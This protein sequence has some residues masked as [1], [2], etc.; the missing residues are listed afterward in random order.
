MLE[1]AFKERLVVDTGG[2]ITF[3][4]GEHVNESTADASIVLTQEFA[5]MFGQT[6]SLNWIPTHALTKGGVQLFG[7]ELEI[8]I[9]PNFHRKFVSANTFR[10]KKDAKMGIAAIALKSGLMDELKEAVAKDPSFGKNSKF[11]DKRKATLPPPSMLAG[12]IKEEDI[13]SMDK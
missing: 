13:P 1:A 6:R 3:K 2:Y 8:D 5:R 11:V 10:N 12:S 9:H 7:S 4:P